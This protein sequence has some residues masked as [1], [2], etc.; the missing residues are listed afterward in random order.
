MSAGNGDQ[1]AEPIAELERELRLTLAA[2][3]QY[4]DSLLD[5]LIELMRE[6]RL[7]LDAR[8]D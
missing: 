1:Y 5:R 8:G 2:H 6:I 3:P 4:A 7:N